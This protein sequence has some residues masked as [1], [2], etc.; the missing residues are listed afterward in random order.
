[1][2]VKHGPC[3]LTLNFF[4]FLIQAFETKCLRKLLHISYLER[5]TNDWVRSKINSLVGQR[6]PLPATV[7]RLKLAR[8]RQVT[9]HNSLSRTILRGTLEGGA[10]RGRQ[11]KCWMDNIKKRTSLPM[12]GLLTRDLL[13]KRPEE[14]LCR[15]VP[16]VPSRR[17]NRSRD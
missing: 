16:R 14:D 15:I 11:W 6:E 13:Q 8:V 12:P 2:T 9:R 3:S 1:M 10:R 5:K 7:S 4:I 17:P